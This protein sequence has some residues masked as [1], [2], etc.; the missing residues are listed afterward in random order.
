MKTKQQILEQITDEAQ[1]KNVEDLINF[2]ETAAKAAEMTEEKFKE[3]LLKQADE[4]QIKIENVANLQEK[5][6]EQSREIAKIREGETTSEK[7]V[8]QIIKEK[9]TEIIKAMDQMK[10]S[11]SL[12]IPVS[13]I[14]K[15]TVTPSSITSNS[16]G[17]RLMEIGQIATRRTVIPE[18][19]AQFRMEDRHNRTV[20][21][22]DQEAVTRGAAG[23]AVASA[24]GESAISW[25][26]RSETLK[27][28]SDKI[29]IAK[30]VIER[31][32]MLEDEIR[33]FIT[34][35]IML[36]RDYDFCN[37]TGS[38]TT[39]KGV[40]TSATEFDS[41]AYTG[42]KPVAG[43][44]YDL[45]MVMAAEI[46]AQTKYMV[47][48]VVINPKDINR[49][50]LTKDLNGS[51]LRPMI[52]TMNGSQIYLDNIRVVESGAQAENTLVI[53]DFTKGRRYFGENISID[54]GYDS[55]G[56]F[57]KR[58]VTMLG[59]M[60]ELLLIRTVEADAFLKCSDITTA[61]GNITSPTS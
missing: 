26:Q 55:S 60:E 31:G 23:R 12:K 52:L 13:S 30:E 9:H 17:M 29:P 21:Y 53:G 11:Y 40:N 39:I 28:I 61:A 2:A 35:N 10:G 25:I 20:Y 42:F 47:D 34:N 33:N 24:A 49:L 4:L 1:R 19:F 43:T 58:I 54:F 18:L 46:M 14:T 6:E 59:N 45:I 41:A 44:M 37:G 57:G 51:M 22:T 15:T 56:D 36:V 50:K 5:M 32:F 38:S 16:A 27:T 48:T 7:S 8:G 3:M